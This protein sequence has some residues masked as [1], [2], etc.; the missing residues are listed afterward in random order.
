MKCL[1]DRHVRRESGGERNARNAHTARGSVEG[2]RAEEEEELAGP[3]LPQCSSISH[4]QQQK[5]PLPR[6]PTH[7]IRLR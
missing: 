4:A 6:N 5:A 7:R 1:Q 2:V 3:L